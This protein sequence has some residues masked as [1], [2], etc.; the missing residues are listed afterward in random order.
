MNE[1]PIVLD[2]FD[3]TLLY[4]TLR[5]GRENMHLFYFQGTLQDFLSLDL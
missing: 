5:E 2:L 4:C 1:C 3:N